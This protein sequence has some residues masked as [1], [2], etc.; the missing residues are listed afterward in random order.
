MNAIAAALSPMVNPPAVADAARGDDARSGEFARCLDQAREGEDCAVND[1]DEAPPRP[2]A[3]ARSGRENMAPRK[4]E[5]NPAKNVASGKEAGAAGATEA[6]AMPTTET[7]ADEATAPDLAALLP[8]WSP[9]AIVVPAPVA[10]ANAG[11]GTDAS[12]D[13]TTTVA[14][15]GAAPLAPRADVIAPAVD[16]PPARR[17]LAID[18]SA[19]SAAAAAG[20][21]LPVVASEPKDALPLSPPTTASALAQPAFAAAMTATTTPNTAAT[22]P[23]PIDAPAFAPSL[24]TQVRWWAND[25]VQ[26]AQL[27]LNPAEMGPVAVKIVLDGRE[28]RIDFSADHAATRS[29]IEAALPVL[30][31][32]LDDGGLKLCGGGVHDGSAQRQNDWHARSVTDRTARASAAEQGHAPAVAA[33][34]NASAGRGLVDLVA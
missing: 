2:L 22:L 20:A 3:K 21:S 7:Q 26:Q 23:A 17:T 9:A 33:P 27:L 1:A 29:A 25:G 31:A 32:A 4:A 24:A 13:I 5:A 14:R 19:T 15:G 8:G 34:R 28:A 12:P 11:D 10:T 18:D 16:E 6:D 30:A